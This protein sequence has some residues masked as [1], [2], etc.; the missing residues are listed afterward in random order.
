M[1]DRTKRYINVFLELIVITMLVLGVSWFRYENGRLEV[2]RDMGGEIVHPQ[3][4]CMLKD[5]VEKILEAQSK[6]LV[7]GLPEEY[8]NLGVT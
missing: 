2:C 8:A 6:P 3:N 4:K 1:N 5:D 7:Q